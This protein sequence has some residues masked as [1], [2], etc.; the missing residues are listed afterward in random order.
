MQVPIRITKSK[1]KPRNYL[2]KVVGMGRAKH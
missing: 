2:E 1:A